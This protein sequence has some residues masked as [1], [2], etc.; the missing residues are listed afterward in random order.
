MALST[1]VLVCAALLEPAVARNAGAAP[2]AIAAVGRFDFEGP[3]PSD[4]RLAPEELSGI[5]W[6]G[7]DRYVAVGDQH[8]CLH[9]LRIRLD[10]EKGCV[11]GVRFEKPVL[12]RDDRARPLPDST[13]GQDREGICYG[14]SSQTVWIANEQTGRDTGRPSLARHS[15]RDGRRTRLLTVDSSPALRIF[16]KQRR[17]RGF[18]SLTVRDDGWETWTAN[19]GPLT[20][21]GRPATDSTGG[22]VRLVKLDKAMRPVAQYAYVVDPYPT[23]IMDPPLLRGFDVSGLSDVLLLP[24]GRLL[25]L[26]R[27]FAGDSTGAA[28][29]RIRIYAVDLAGATDVSRPPLADG[30]AG[31]S[32]APAGKRLLWGEDFGLGNSNFEG[33]TLGP[34]LRNGDRALLLV[35]DNN[36]GSA[37]SLYALRLSGLGR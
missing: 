27:A 32:Y 34:K 36:E 18:E 7:G 15:V 23:R 25:A 14:R 11:T 30:L 4:R 8:A 35:A 28:N 21:D 24:D 12:L 19:E 37:Q 33:I 29:L 20:A 10:P 2:L 26:E 6:M 9:F 17:N 22:V 3:A 1:A 5:A 31:A 16:A 13:E